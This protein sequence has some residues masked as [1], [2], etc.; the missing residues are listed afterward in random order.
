[1]EE[2]WTLGIIMMR[3]QSESWNILMIL[4]LTAR[5]IMSMRIGFRL[6]ITIEKCGAKILKGERSLILVTRY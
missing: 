2:T 5:D 1:M 6:M 3:W 4:I